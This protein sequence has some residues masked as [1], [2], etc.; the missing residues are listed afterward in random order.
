ME[1]P[2]LHIGADVGKMKAALPEITKALVA[3]L[4]TSAGDSVKVAAIGA[5]SKAFSV[6]HVTISDCS[7]TSAE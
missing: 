7:F 2:M 5:L 6:E 1:A 3:I 4:N